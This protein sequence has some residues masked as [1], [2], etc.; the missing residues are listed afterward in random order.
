MCKTILYMKVVKRAIHFFSLSLFFFGDRLYIHGVWV[1]EFFIFTHCC[2]KKKV[3]EALA[4]PHWQIKKPFT[5][6]LTFSISLLKSLITFKSL[7]REFL[8]LQYEKEHFGT[9]FSILSLIEWK[10][11]KKPRDCWQ[12]R[13]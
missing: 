9:D 8:I 13:I 4:R 5:H 12:V 7:K 6:I 2:G 11:S 1:F 3:G 10:K